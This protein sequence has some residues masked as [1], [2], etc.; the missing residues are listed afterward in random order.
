MAGN[1]I[2]ILKIAEEAGVSKS[3]VSRVLNNQPGVMPET[4]LRVLEV[5]DK[6]HFRPNIYARNISRRRSNS[7]GVVFS[8]D[9]DFVFKNP[10]YTELQQNIMKT[11]K[12]HDYYTLLIC[13]ED[14]NEAAEMI[15]RNQVDGLIIV[16]PREME[17]EKLNNL[18]KQDIPMVCITNSKISVPCC[19]FYSD[20]Y[21]GATLAMQHLIN[22]G[23]KRIGYVNG[24]HFLLSSA[25]RYRAYW[26]IMT[27]RKYAIT[28][29]LVQEGNNSI[30]SGYTAAQ[31][32]M[33][34][35]PDITAFAVA[36]DNMAIGVENAVREAGLKIPGDISVI[37][38]DNIAM[39]EQITPPLT[40]IDQ[41]T[42]ARARL[43]VEKLLS[44]I[45]G[46]RVGSDDY[47]FDLPP[48]L[49]V[50]GST[51]PVCRGI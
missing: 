50:R 2:T 48:F 7:I 51:G 27:Q 44:L 28:A 20:S 22:L 32:I 39:S 12:H 23:H 19:Q 35:N 36:S 24:P 8:Q 37:G 42:A 18:C 16:S 45:E 5:I 21:A 49:V 3:T 38:F 25:E 15:M 17:F 30:E 13:S 11:A 40:T 41:Q 1:M 14:L 34:E 10:F 6:Y 31:A 47:Y 4:R 9:F 33:H 46:E 26:D 43:S 29:G